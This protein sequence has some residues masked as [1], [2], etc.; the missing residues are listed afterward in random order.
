[1]P[2]I[3]LLDGRV[4]LAQR[5][6][7]LSIGLLVEDDRHPEACRVIVDVGPV[8]QHQPLDRNDFEVV[9]A[10]RVHGAVSGNH[11]EAR[12]TSRAHVHLADRAGE[13]IG[14]EPLAEG[15]GIGPRGEHRVARGVENSNE[16]D[17][18][19]E[20]PRRR[21]GDGGVLLM[22]SPMSVGMRFGQLCAGG[23]HRAGRDAAPTQLG[24]ARPMRRSRPAAPAAAGMAAVVHPAATDQTRPLEDLQMTGDGRE[25]DRERLGQLEHGRLTVGQPTHDRAPRRVRQGGE[26]DVEP[27]GGR[28][29]HRCRRSCRYFTG[30]LFN[31]TTTYSQGRCRRGTSLQ[32]AD[33]CEDAVTGV[34]R[35]WR[36]IC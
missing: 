31:R 25:A 19:I 1:M 4:E 26:D 11:V 32:N 6:H 17:L 16:D 13:P 23:A 30:W 10:I 2:R 36:L 21:I 15:I 22:A 18:T 5:Q 29:G 33:G 3:S 24:C 8:I 7:R 28:H 27:I 20:R 34:V 12:S 9:E 14:T 35:S